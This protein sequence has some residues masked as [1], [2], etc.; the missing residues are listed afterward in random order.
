MQLVLHVAN[1]FNKG[2]FQECIK[3]GV[4][5]CNI[6]DAMNR[7]FTKVQREKAGRAPLTIVIKEGTLAIQK[8]VKLDW[9]GST[10]KA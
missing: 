1:D 9:V 8:A 5:K 7:E 3:R 10:R 2:L 4:A 6:K